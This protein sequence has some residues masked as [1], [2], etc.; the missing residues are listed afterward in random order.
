MKKVVMSL[1]Q[2]L[3]KIKQAYKLF[4]KKQSQEECIATDE[5]LF[6]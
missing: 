4:G 3:F 5:V 6:V 2:S 1:R